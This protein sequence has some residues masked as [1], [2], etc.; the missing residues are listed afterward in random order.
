M[1]NYSIINNKHKLILNILIKELKAVKHN[2][3]IWFMLANQDIKLRY[4]RSSLGPLWITISMAI[5]IFTMGFLYGH[6]F[7]IKLHSYLPYLASGIIS[8]TFISTLILESS[9]IFIESEMYIKNQESYLSLFVMRLIW[10]NIII[11][12]HNLLP[13]IPIMLFFKIFSWQLFLFIPGLFIVGCNFFLWG[14]LLAIVGTRYRD[15]LQ[16]IGS[17]TQIIFFVTPIMWTPEL[18]PAKYYWLI[19]INPFNQ[20][21]NLIR[22]PMLGNSVDLIDLILV[23]NITIMGFIL[24]VKFINK[25]KYR[26]VFWL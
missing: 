10:R 26:V 24:Y 20:M 1:R 22:Q 8:W 19:K 7:K 12:G 21:L 23:M 11:L 6:L 4:R 16:I 18:L 5:T 3:L 13:Y 25:Y 15:F 14:T 17:I 9:N 2:C